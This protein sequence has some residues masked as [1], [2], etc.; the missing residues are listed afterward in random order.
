[1][2][3][4]FKQELPMLSFFFFSIDFSPVKIRARQW[5]R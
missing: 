3:A 4:E 2:D 5:S 1:M